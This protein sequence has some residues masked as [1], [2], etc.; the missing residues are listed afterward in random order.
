M[1]GSRTAAMGRVVRAVAVIDQPSTTDCELLRRFSCKND[2][3]AFETLVNR[4]T[5]MVFGV[6][7]RAL[8]TVQDAEDACQATF[9][10]LANR[11][12]DGRWQKSVANW[13]YTTARKVAH[14]ARVA[15]ERRARRETRAALPEAVE[16]VDRMTGR[17]L[18]AALDSA[19]ACLSPRYREPLVLC[20][21][22]GLTHQEAAIRLGVPL[23]TLHT[24]IDW[25]R[26][27]LY[28]V[29][30]KAGCTLGAGLLVLRV[31]SP[32]GASSPRLVKSILTTVSKSVPPAVGELAKGLAVNGLLQKTTLAVATMIGITVLAA[33]LWSVGSSAAG[34]PQVETTSM[35]AEPSPAA[36]EPLNA[37][38]RTTAPEKDEKPKESP[39]SGRVLGM[40]GKPFAGAELLFVKEG[41]KPKKLGI[42][43]PDGRFTFTVSHGEKGVNLIARADG[44]GIDFV[45]LGRIPLTAET[46]LRLGKDHPIRGRIVDTQGKPVSG[47]T[48]QVQSVTIYGNNSLDLFLAEWKSREQYS[49]HPFPPGA[50]HISD[51]VLFPPVKTDKDGR[52]TVTGAGAERTVGL[53]IKGA[54]IASE[55]IYVV[56]RPEFDPN[57]YNKMMEDKIAMFGYGSRKDPLH[58]PELAL[59]AEAEKPIRGVVKDKDTGKPRAG[60]EVTLSRYGKYF[61]AFS[62]VKLSAITDAE[63]RF[64]LHG[65]RKSKAYTID[66]WSDATTGY[67]SL[68]VHVDD[69]AGYEPISIDLATKKGVI[70]TGRVI[71]KG[72]GK[73]ISGFVMTGALNANPFVRDYPGEKHYEEYASTGLDGTFRIIAFPGPVILMGGPDPNRLPEGKLAWYR[74]KPIKTDPMYPEYFMK[75]DEASFAEYVGADGQTSPVQGTACK[76]LKV[77][78]GISTIEQ[79][80][81]LEPATAL[82][83][84]IRDAD[85]KPVA[86]VLATGF[87]RE[88]MWG[89][90]EVKGDTTVAYHLEGKPRL[91]VFYEPTRK[92]FGTLALKGDETESVT[93]KLGPGGSVE[94]RAIGE[95]GKPL[96]GVAV[97]L[98]HQDRRAEKV[99]SYIHRDRS[100]ETD[101][102]GKFRI[103]DVVPGLKFNLSFS[104]GKQLFELAAKA[105]D[106]K[107]ES[108]KTTDAGK[109]ELKLKPQRGE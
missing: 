6:C 74:Y 22:E 91:M 2:Q 68:R 34:R 40:D 10:V 28:R 100:V 35:T 96:V 78:A 43:G 83:V 63:G 102:D 103:D 29:L 30:T 3:G 61:A 104:R 26:K 13:L 89:P 107:S 84:K 60:V 64:E 92:L 31:S 81:I 71:D 25:A 88:D 47:A 50:K 56:N 44:V 32:A 5:G 9:L 62:S 76:V 39:V 82:P 86:G 1:S 37:Y 101:L 15:A 72:T 38:P 4:H 65:A 16:P 95:D 77:E 12:K 17:E 45:D 109:L 66:M 55:E 73:P 58:G 27:R 33:G 54:G 24:R 90:E 21:L 93:A 42:S 20:Y 70:I 36:A 87:G 99:H 7:R 105:A 80:L 48:V 23:G 69:T 49:G 11:A 19:L 98:K 53:H 18:L 51:G 94:G 97:H 106:L 108:G 67:V 75:E 79:D 46:E 57:P 14:N 52:F 41:G 8:P 85:G 59:I